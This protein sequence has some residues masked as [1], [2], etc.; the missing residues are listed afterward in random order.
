MR[1]E[2]FGTWY[3]KPYN[4]RMDESLRE[5]Q[6]KS[7]DSQIATVGGATVF[8]PHSRSSYDRMG[9]PDSQELLLAT[10]VGGYMESRE[11]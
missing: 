9:R 8:N 10:S 2:R 6:R 3:I 1:N 7:R 11:K 5:L 4:M